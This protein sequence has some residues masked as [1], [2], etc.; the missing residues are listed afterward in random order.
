VPL[1]TVDERPLIA[2]VGDA[3]RCK[4]PAEARKAAEQLGAEL[5][6]HGC[7]VRV[8][9]SSPEF[10]EWEVVR[11]YLDAN[12]KVAPKSIEV[13]YPPELDGLFEGEKPDDPR[14]SRARQQGDWE[15]S[16]YPSFAEVHGL[17]IMGG[18]Y[19]T[20]ILGLLALGSRTPL[21]T[22]AGMGGAAE[23]VWRYIQA[24]RHRTTTDDELNLMI[25]PRWHERSAARLVEVLLEQR[26]RQLDEQRQRALG[27]SERRRRQ[28]LTRLAMLGSA[29]FLI[30]LALFAEMAAS[31]NVPRLWTWFLFGAP[32]IAG[33]SGAAIRVLWDNWDRRDTL[34]LRPMAMT[35]ALGFWAAGVAA[36][37]FILSQLWVSGD[38]NALSETSVKRLAGFAVAVGLIAGLTL[39]K[40]FPKL[41][42]VDI[43]VELPASP[44]AGEAAAPML[45]K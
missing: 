14:F 22:L 37:L 45:D 43:P 17:V 31:P 9:S 29:L 27:A 40:V 15:A 32:A 13:R 6:R 24:D 39:D 33:A 28:M 18:A 21:V 20:K 8:F 12:V 16:I 1:P 36:A 34:D 11:G 25:N 38:L 5:A 42:K 2:V 3:R 44:K 7:R 35:I 10:I 19:T 30:V 26:Q 4:D 23:E 41:L